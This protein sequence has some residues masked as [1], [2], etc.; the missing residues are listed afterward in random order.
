MDI[1]EQLYNECKENLENRLQVIQNNILDIETAL[2]SETKSSAGDKHETGR[3]ML[4]LEREKLGQRLAEI[5]KLQDLLQKTDYKA[6]HTKVALGSIV[7]TS[8]LNYYIAI[9]TGELKINETCFYAISPATPIAQVLL[10]KEEGDVVS[11]R[12]ST[13]T[14]LK[15]M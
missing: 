1:K 13:F 5:Q 3:A 7:F 15:V 11:F 14:V 8:N 6:T 4:Q 9:S 2:Q 12:N 10:G